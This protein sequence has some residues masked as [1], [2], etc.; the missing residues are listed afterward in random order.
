MPLIYCH[1]MKG[2]FSMKEI[3]E[4]PE[5]SVHEFSAIDVI[6]TSGLPPTPVWP[7][8]APDYENAWGD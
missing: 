3:Y 5:M 1:V 4:N 2:V 8:D 6:T 7:D